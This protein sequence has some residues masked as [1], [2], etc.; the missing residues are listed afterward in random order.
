M[1]IQTEVL[2]V[3]FVHEHA[4]G[5]LEVEGSLKCDPNNIL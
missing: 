1:I 5:Y 4:V 2:M 3:I